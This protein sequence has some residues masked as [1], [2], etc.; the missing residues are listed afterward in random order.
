MGFVQHGEVKITGAAGQLVASIKG[1]GRKIDHIQ[2]LLDM[3]LAGLP[4]GIGAVPIV[5]PVGG[6]GILLDL[7]TRQPAPKAC[8]SPAETG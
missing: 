7:A 1:S 2:R 6:I 4:L 5:D 8:T 3:E